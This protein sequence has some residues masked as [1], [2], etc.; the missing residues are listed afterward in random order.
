[1]GMSWLGVHKYS[2]GLATLTSGWDLFAGASEVLNR[3]T[4]PFDRS[5]DEHLDQRE[6]LLVFLC[7]C[8][9]DPA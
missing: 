3:D 2:S 5:R 9:R 4:Q 6:D 8:A 1:M 7:P